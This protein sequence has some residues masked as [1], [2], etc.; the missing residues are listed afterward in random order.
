MTLW[1]GNSKEVGVKTKEP[2]VGGRGYE[3]F[4]EPHVLI[5]IEG[6]Y[7]RTIRAVLN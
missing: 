3:Y 6:Q 7:P 5:L 1:K 4:L 2:S